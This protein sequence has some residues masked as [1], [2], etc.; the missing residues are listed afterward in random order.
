VL[1]EQGIPN[2]TEFGDRKLS[3]RAEQ[4]IVLTNASAHETGLYSLVLPREPCPSWLQRRWTHERSAACREHDAWIPF[5]YGRGGT[6]IF[7]LANLGHAGI[8]S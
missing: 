7:W 2:A 5:L 1:E 8:S 3:V 6:L 4:K